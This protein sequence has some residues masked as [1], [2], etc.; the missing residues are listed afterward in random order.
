M[1]RIPLILTLTLVAL[2]AFPGVAFAAGWPDGKV[3]LGGT[4]TLRSGEV[5]DGDLVV[6][7]GIATLEVGSEVTGTVALIGGMVDA[8][9]VI[10]EGIGAVGA[11]VNLASTAVV[12]GDVVT[13]GASITRA[14]GAVVEGRITEGEAE[15]PFGFNMPGV[16]VPQI[17]RVAVDVGPFSGAMR[18]GWFFMRAFLYA[19]VAV[20]V[21]LFWPLR[22]GRVAQTAVAQPVISAGLGLLTLLLGIPVLLILGLTICLAPVAILGGIV[23]GVAAALGWIAIGLELG[24]RMAAAFR[25]DWSLAASAGVGTLVLTLVA[26]AFDLMFGPCFGFWVPAVVYWL[27]LG[28]VI[29]TRFG[30]QDYLGTPTAAPM[31]R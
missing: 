7:G 24:Q 21:A 17:P 28:A 19:A 31:V 26:Y 15:G 11:S 2:L 9:G 5:L 3:V 22:T 25:Q 16:I 27:G 6:V 29:L 12:H 10:G 18:V 30:G 14:E 4:Y 13:M 1:K 20:L 8:A 23:L